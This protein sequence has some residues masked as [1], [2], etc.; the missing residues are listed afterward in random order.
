MG[1]F[2]RKSSADTFDQLSDFE[3]ST[4]VSAGC[5]ESDFS[6]PSPPPRA[7]P[8]DERVRSIIFDLR[9]AAGSDQPAW[10][11]GGAVCALEE[12]VKARD[13]EQLDLDD[14]V[15]MQ[16]AVIEAAHV[17]LHHHTAAR[18]VEDIGIGLSAVIKLLKRWA[19]GDGH[20]LAAGLSEEIRILRNALHNA[21]LHVRRRERELTQQHRRAACLFEEIFGPDV[22]GVQ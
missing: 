7:S 13:A 3:G 15:D 4:M 1:A 11:L 5:L 10:E 18:Y 12:A 19:C 2:H 22:R 16:L 6:E 14:L 9:R 8:H 17:V 20:P 21:D